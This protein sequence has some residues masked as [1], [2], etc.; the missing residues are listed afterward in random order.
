MPKLSRGSFQYINVCGATTVDIPAVLGRNT[1]I[2]GSSKSQQLAL[3]KTKVLG[4]GPA[5]LADELIDRACLPQ[6]KCLFSSIQYTPINKGYLILAL[7]SG[8]SQSQK[9]L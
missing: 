1:K 6:N 2:H 5:P 4:T 7:N 9:Y 8:D 3:M